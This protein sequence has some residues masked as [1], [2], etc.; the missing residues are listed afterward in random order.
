MLCQQT[1]AE[2][3]ARNR[4]SDCIALQCVAAETA[5]ELRVLRRFN[6]FG[7][8][9]YPERL[10]YIDDRPD[11]TSLFA[12]Y[13]DRHDQPLIDFQPFGLSFSSPMIDA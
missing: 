3:C 8:H 6:T 5:Q 2:I 7:D 13:R 9:A 12:G 10:G 4:I 11:K 1:S